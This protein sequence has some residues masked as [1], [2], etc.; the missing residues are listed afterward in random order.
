MTGLRNLMTACGVVLL[1]AGCAGMS[2]SGS[3]AKINKS[4]VAN[5]RAEANAIEKQGKL[6]EAAA[7]YAKIYAAD[8][9]DIGSLVG[10]SRTLRKMGHVT[11]ARNVME[12]DSARFSSNP[13]YLVELAKIDLAEKKS[14]EAI[15]HADAA[16]KADPDHW[17]AYS[18]MGVAL[19]MKGDYATAAGHYQKA[20]TLSKGD[21]G[22]LNN[23]ALSRAQAGDLNKGIALLQDAV[24]QGK[25][26]PEVRQN[27]ALLYG[28]QGKYEKA[29]AVGEMDLDSKSV[30]SN[31]SYYKRFSGGTGG[32]PKKLRVN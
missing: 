3:N 9:S 17:P 6:K 22:V 8:E 5:L 16:I 27:L 1:L 31:I 30:E 21:P 11:R 13:F 28:V 14:N 23:Y 4:A 25:A 2:Q 15:S 18:V 7:M 10:F 24:T 19:D 29:K 12:Q 26:T 32:K 20:L